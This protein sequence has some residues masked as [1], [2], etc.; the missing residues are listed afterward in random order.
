MKFFCKILT[1]AAVLSFAIGAYATKTPVKMSKKN[2]KYLKLKNQREFNE[3]SSITTSDSQPIYYPKSTRDD[4]YSSFSLVDS[5][6]NGYGLIVAPTR[7]L[8]VTEDGWLMVY[9]QFVEYP[10]GFSG[11]LGSAYSSNGEN[12]TTYTNLNAGGAMTGAGT[13]MARYPSAIMSADYPYAIWNEYTTQTGTYGGRPYYSWD[14]FGFGGNSWSYP[15]DSDPLWDPLKDL[16]V[17][18]PSYS[19]DESGMGHFNISYSDWTRTEG[20]R[21]FTSEFVDASGQIIFGAENLIFNEQQ[22]FVG[23]DDEG[24]FTSSPVTAFNGAGTGY[25]AVTAY[26]AGADLEASPYDNYHTMFLRKTEDH[27]MTWSE[28][29]NHDGT[30]YY[31]VPDDVMLRLMENY[32]GTGYYDECDL[33]EYVFSGVFMAYDFDMKVDSEG[34]PHFVVGVLAEGPDPVSGDNYIFP[35]QDGSGYYYFTID[36]ENLDDPG[37]P[38]DLGS[39]NCVGSTGWKFSKVMDTQDCWGFQTP[40]GGSYWQTAFPS[41]AISEESEDHMWVVSTLFVP[42]EGNDPTPEDPCDYNTIYDLGTEDLVVTKTTD[43]GDYWWGSYNV[44]STPADPSTEW[45]D[46]AENSAHVG[47]GATND[48]VNVV[49]QMPKWDWNTTGDPDGPDH[50]C[51]LYAGFVEYTEEEK[52]YVVGDANCDSQVTIQDIIML[53]QYILGQANIDCGEGNGVLGADYNEDG[54]ISVNDVIEIVNYI[55]TETKSKSATWVKM[56]NNSSN[57]SYDSNGEVGAFDITISHDEGFDLQLTDDAMVAFSENYGK[58]TR[59]IIVLPGASELFFTDDKFE[60][61]DIYVVSRDGDIEV[62]KP[63]QLSLSEAYPNPFNPTT[64]FKV[65]MN[66]EGVLNVAVYN[67][68][69]QLVD[70]LYNGYVASGFHQ[71]SWNAGNQ[72]SGLYIVKASDG[73]RVVSQKVMLLK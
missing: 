67:V 33:V 9:R 70:V 64:S 18:S 48:R 49:Y 24:S 1:I 66:E 6:M 54:I 7:P 5:S 12:W 4:N 63:N 13:P 71:Y 50:T 16:W 8:D 26:W 38:C 59:M 46:L 44:S 41:F 62:I 57:L 14:Q 31:T 52:D 72:A 45:D 55:L 21:L 30:P 42:G 15:E 32:F 34:N 37:T 17:G 27:G 39:E 51:R 68:A 3:V 25:V 43:G 61:Q 73:N 65:S 11:Q 36:K 19:V 35:D 69:G 2:T 29:S 22:W 56:I 40:S 58:T 10:G 23:G 47:V 28:S 53:V 60:I 20:P